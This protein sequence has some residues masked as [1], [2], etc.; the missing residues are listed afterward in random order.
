MEHGLPGSRGF[1]QRGQHNKAYLPRSQVSLGNRGWNNGGQPK[2]ANAA[3]D[4]QDGVWGGVQ[5][6]SLRS[7]QL[8]CCWEKPLMLLSCSATPPPTVNRQPPTCSGFRHKRYKYNFYEPTLLACA[9]DYPMPSPLLSHHVS[10]ISHLPSL[11][12]PLAMLQSLEGGQAWQAAQLSEGTGMWNSH[13]F[14]G[15]R[16]CRWLAELSSSPSVGLRYY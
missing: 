7:G 16:R 3:R 4:G 14:L 1:K 12:P 6:W 8:L 9:F 13:L 10:P 2:K 5:S 11:K 15:F